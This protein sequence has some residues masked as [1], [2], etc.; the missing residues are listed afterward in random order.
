MAIEIKI[1]RLGWS[2]EEGTFVGWLKKDGESVKAGEPLFTL[3]S[4]KA[5]QDIE[6]IDSGIL[7]IPADAPQ[8]GVVV[9]V[10][11]VI[12]H[13]VEDGEGTEKD[14]AIQ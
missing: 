5:S 10:G 4:E 14:A 13:F 2:M 12:G 1:P 11:Q 8:P 6:S 3:E 9:K 7:R